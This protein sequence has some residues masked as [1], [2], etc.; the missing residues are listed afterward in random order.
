MRQWP[1]LG[2]NG[3]TVGSGDFYGAATKVYHST[4]RVEL[5]RCGAVGKSEF[6]GEQSEDCCDS[7][8][9]SSC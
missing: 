6:V 9:V 7:V 2:M 8:V 4:D 3:S 5:V 1:F